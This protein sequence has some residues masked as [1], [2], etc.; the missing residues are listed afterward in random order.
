MPAPY[1]RRFAIQDEIVNW[2]DFAMA[3]TTDG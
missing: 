2:A 3:L 1:A